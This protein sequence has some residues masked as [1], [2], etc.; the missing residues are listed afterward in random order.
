MLLC[1]L[2][3]NQRE[4]GESVVKGYDDGIIHSVLI[5]FWTLPGI[6]PK[7]IQGIDPYCLSDISD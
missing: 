3:D 1:G 7:G 4:M 6:Y 2:G 5:V